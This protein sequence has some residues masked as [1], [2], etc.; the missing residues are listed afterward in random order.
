MSGEKYDKQPSFA[1]TESICCLI[2]GSN[3]AKYFKSARKFPR[4][5]SPTSDSGDLKET[6]AVEQES[7]LWQ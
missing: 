7:E 4:L 1:E 3:F 6:K 5:E 2:T